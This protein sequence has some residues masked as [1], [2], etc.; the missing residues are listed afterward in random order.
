MVSL[1]KKPSFS[2]EMCFAF[3]WIWWIRFLTLYIFSTKLIRK[4]KCWKPNNN[5]S[6]IIAIFKNTC[7]SIRIQRS[8]T[9]ETSGIVLT[10]A[11]EN[12][13]SEIL[14]SRNTKIHLPFTPE[15]KFKND[16]TCYKMSWRFSFANTDL[17]VIQKIKLIPTWT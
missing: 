2:R 13:S 5:S 1:R 16:R 7:F 10:K 17:A 12:R 15:S 6:K 11:G 3:V 14:P 8:L 4:K 9:K